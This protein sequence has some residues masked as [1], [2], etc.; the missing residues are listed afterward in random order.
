MPIARGGGDERVHDRRHRD[1][2]ARS[3]TTATGSSIPALAAAAVLGVQLGSVGRDALRRERASAWWLK[4]LMASAAADDRR[5][6]DAPGPLTASRPDDASQSPHLETARSAACSAPA[7]R[8]L[9]LPPRRRAALLSL[10]G[11]GGDREP[12]AAD[13]HRYVLL[14]TPVARVF[15][16]ILEYA[17]ERDWKF[18]LLTA[19]VLVGAPGESRWP[20]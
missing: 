15:V 1:A 2:P 8:Q 14:A 20:R 16:S 11:A 9:G 3:S 17:S 13:R 18:T 19:I 12:A 10:A 6:D 4:L 7:S 5:D